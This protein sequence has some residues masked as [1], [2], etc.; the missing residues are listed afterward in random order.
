MFVLGSFGIFFSSLFKRTMISVIV[1]YGV[2][3][4]IFGGTA[5]VFFVLLGVIN[6]MPQTTTNSYSWLGH[7]IAWNPVAAL[8][9]ILDP[10]I[11][12]MAFTVNMNNSSEKNAPLP[13]WQEFVIIYT[14]LSSGALWL[15]IRG[16][17]PRV[18]RKPRKSTEEVFV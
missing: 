8:Y 7:V 1:T 12:E 14:L 15:G 3:L 9:S 6:Q 2:T 18:K 11:S 10:S 4:F 17:R 5:I 16:L 13:L